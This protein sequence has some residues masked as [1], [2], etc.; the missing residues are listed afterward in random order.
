MSQVVLEILSKIESLSQKERAELAQ[1]FLDSLDLGDALSTEAFD[2][3][4][5]ARLDQIEAGTAVGR[6]AAEIFAELRGQR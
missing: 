4:L 3:E 1:A 6:P 5:D 2:A